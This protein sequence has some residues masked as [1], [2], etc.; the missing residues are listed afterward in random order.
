M[1]P[2]DKKKLIASNA[3]ILVVGILVSFVLPMIGDSM[4]EGRSAFLRMIL[5]V[6]PLIVSMSASTAIINKSI[7]AST[8]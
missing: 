1:K 3:G 6:F 2:A 7:G 5:H 4:T 8:D